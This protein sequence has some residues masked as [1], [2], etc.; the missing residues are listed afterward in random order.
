IPLGVLV[1]VTGVS[2]SGKSTLVGDILYPALARHFGHSAELPGQHDDITGIEHLS[3]IV[4]VDQKAIGKTTRSNPASFV[5]AWDA[6]RK[7]F[8]RQPLASE[9]G[10]KPG[11]FSFNSG[12]GRCPTC[13]GTGFEHIEMQFLSD[14]YLRCPDCDG[15]RFRD[16]ILEVRVF[17]AT[18]DGPSQSVA[19]VL[20]MTVS[21]AL[22]FFSDNKELQRVLQP[23]VDV[24]L[25]YVKLGQPVPTLSGGESQRLKLARHL[26]EA[27]KARTNK[28]NKLFLF[29]EPT[30]GLHFTDIEKLLAAF[31]QLLEEGH[32]VLLVEHNLDVI[33]AADWTIDL[34]PEGG[35][36]GGECLYQGPQAGLTQ[37]RGNATGDALRAYTVAETVKEASTV[38]TAAGKAKRGDRDI[39]IQ[40]AREH[41]LRNVD[42]QVPHNKFTAITGVSG[43]G[44]STI[45]FDILF[46][47]GQ[48]RYLESLNAYTRQF[49][50]PASRPDVDA[51]TAIPPTV[52]I[53]QRTS[54]GGRKSTVGTLTEVYHF[55]R[56]LF[57]K[58][59][60]AYC[61][62]CDV[63]IQPQ[64]QEQI[65]AQLLKSRHGKAITLM[66]PL[67]RA[68][69]GYYTDLAKWA[70][71][72]GFTELRVDGQ[73]TPVNPWP[74]LD[75]YSEHDIELPVTTLTVDRQ[76]ESDL[77]G[78]LERAL[79][80]GKG[81]VI[82]SDSEGRQRD[83]L[84]STER[85]CPSCNRS[86]PELDPRLFSY[87]SAQGWCPTCQ[88][89]GGSPVSEDVADEPAAPSDEGVCPS[90]N[91]QRL[92]ETALAVRLGERNIAA[93][94]ELPV[95]ELRSA[96]D[97]LK[98]K[99][100]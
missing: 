14:V 57:V 97:S 49:V 44:K 47:E 8:A 36:R 30:T 6:V 72:K 34:G 79:D 35:E 85:A 40:N 83:T 25:E 1:A 19:D 54:R 65:A 69:K 2:G 7:L 73:M 38:Y 67:V 96:V 71:G 82:I 70:E 10:Y 77:L 39:R 43:S 95:A 33:E 26:G 56:L 74:R 58:L 98:L 23:L 21:E 76:R 94:N 78:A 92:N 29:D 42:V 99:G 88:G 90:C 60:T 55:L 9:R 86:F 48:R 50:Q 16:E 61:P 20:E 31:E 45:A 52:A 27:R 28:G 64:T 80:Y 89:T 24:G 37:L 91:G 66:A 81:V 68:R 3:D 51:V 87:N 4:F 13:G 17:P 22:S 11:T 5:G 84:Y 46:N 41:N 100:R 93:F 15:K 62:D 75:R 18:G 59:G 63:K 12:T 32:S 53:E